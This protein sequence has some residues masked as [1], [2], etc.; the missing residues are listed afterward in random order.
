MSSRMFLLIFFYLTSF[1]TEAI[2]APVPLRLE[3][4]VDPKISYTESKRAVCIT[5]HYPLTV[6]TTN[7]NLLLPIPEN[8]AIVT[9][10]EQEDLSVDSKLASR[11]NG[12]NRTFTDTYSIFL[13]L[14][15]P[16]DPKLAANVSTIQI[17]THGENLDSTY[18][19]PAPGYS[20]LDPAASAGYATLSYDRLGIGQSDHPDPHQVVQSSMH[21]EILHRLVNLTRGGELADHD[22]KHLVGVGHSYGSHITLGTTA[23]YPKDFDAVILTGI[24]T[25]PDHWQ[26]VS[27]AQTSRVANT[28]Q[29]EEWKGL[30]NGYLTQGSDEA[31]RFQ[32]F[33]WPFYDPKGWS[34]FF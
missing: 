23:R 19:D 29:R 11:I 2:Q 3:G 25:K 21:V 28:M 13:K 1:A 30:S 26:L 5:D 15:F 17:L 12:G 20:Y 7:V 6:T 8:Q 33:K 31:F 14:C 24:S 16:S 34:F 32:S 10:L 18:W 22:F 27:A 9:A 4:F